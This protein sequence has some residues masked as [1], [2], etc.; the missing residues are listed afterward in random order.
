LAGIHGTAGV[1]GFD[2]NLGRL[3]VGGRRGVLFHGGAKFIE[4]AIVLGVF[5]S[6]TGLDRLSTF[7]LHAT[8][9]EAALLA[10]VE[11]EIT[12]GTFSLWIKTGNQDGATIGATRA[13]DGAN[14]TGSAGAEMIGSPA[15]PAL[16]RLAIRLIP[17]LLLVLLFGVAIAA[18]TVLAIHK[19]LRA[20]VLTD[21]NYTIY[22]LNKT[23][24]FAK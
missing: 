16:G 13:S 18:V 2:G 7:K 10:T 24:L 21:C 8:I 22:N 23:I 1:R 15:G 14:H 3:H 4:L 19:C 6:N 5:R 20:T 11:L 12:L 9:E 17:L